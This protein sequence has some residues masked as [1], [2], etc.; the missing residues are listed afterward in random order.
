MEF[1][2]QLIRALSEKGIYQA[3]KMSIEEMRKLLAELQRVDEVMNNDKRADHCGNRQITERN[4]T[5]VQRK[6]AKRT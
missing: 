5:T 1:R 4:T 6:Q 2:E 3:R